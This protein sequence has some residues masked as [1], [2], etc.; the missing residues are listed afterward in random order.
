[1]KLWLQAGCSS[2][3]LTERRTSSS[4][5]AHRRAGHLGAEAQLRLLHLLVQ[6]EAGLVLDAAGLLLGGGHQA[7]LLVHRLFLDGG[8][9]GGDLL[10]EVGQAPL[11]LREAGLGGGAGLRRLL[12]VLLH[13]LVAG[14]QG[15][16]DGLAPEEAEDDDQDAE[17]EELEGEASWDR[18]PCSPWPPPCSPPP[19]GSAAV[20]PLGRTRCSQAPRSRRTSGQRPTSDQRDELAHHA[21]LRPRTFSA[22]SRPSASARAGQRWRVSA[23]PGRPRPGR[24]PRP[25][26]SG[27]LAWAAGQDLLLAALGLGAH[28]GAL[29]LPARRASASSASTLASRAAAS[30]SRRLASSL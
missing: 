8:A 23:L 18:V 26:S 22:A 21:T 16:V 30:A 4:A 6:Q 14:G 29:A 20:S 17:V 12:Q 9:Q 15:L 27:R 10:L 28:A 25:A 5:I 1:M 2:S 7:L 19:R 24:A 11:L 3:G 13:L